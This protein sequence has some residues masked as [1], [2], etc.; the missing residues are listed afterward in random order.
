MSDEQDDKRDKI[1]KFI[2]GIN[3]RDL[4]WTAGETRL[5]R[6]PLAEFQ[7]K[8]YLGID[9][10]A[11]ERSEAPRLLKRQDHHDRH[12]DWRNE[13]GHNWTTPIKDQG[14]CGSCVSF[15]TVALLESRYAM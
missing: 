10:A 13:K 12:K 15:A 6:V 1:L 4:G 8:K 5:A 2:R 3:V 7:A 14:P 11:K 9:E